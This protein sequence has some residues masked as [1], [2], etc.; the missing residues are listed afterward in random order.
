MRNRDLIFCITVPSKA[1]PRSGESINV[2]WIHDLRLKD[3]RICPFRDE[4]YVT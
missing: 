4:R 2:D 1:S 3:A